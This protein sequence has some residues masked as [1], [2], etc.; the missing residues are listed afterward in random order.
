MAPIPFEPSELSE[1]RIARYVTGACSDAEAAETRAW[2]AADP[3]RAAHAAALAR[4]WAAARDVP[5][6]HDAAAAWRAV[7][8]RIERL[9]GAAAPGPPT[10]AAVPA[11][12][13]RGVAGPPRAAGRR[14]LARRVASGLAAAGALAAGGMMLWRSA[15]ARDAEPR[16]AADRGREFTTRRGQ[17]AKIVLLD[18]TRVDL[19]AASR[20][21]MRAF[22]AG[23]REVELDGEAVFD[24]VHDPARPFLVRARNAVTEDLG[25]RFGV[26]AYADEAHV[27]VVVASGEV[28]LRPA[29][30]PAGT[31]ALLGAGDAARLDA[32][33]RSQVESGV[34]LDDALGWVRG[35]LV[36]ARTP[37]GEAVPD[38]E[39][40]YDVRI[41]LA[42]PAL[43]TRRVTATFETES[44]GAAMG[45]LALLVGAR[46]ELR[47]REVVFSP[48]THP[49]AATDAR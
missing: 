23:S 29:G 8:E 18:G 27:R 20:L 34:S 1:R 13:P 14:R 19:A 30:A 28:A 4:V 48:L 33:G 3:A 25:T 35:R 49:P 41:R 21:R 16:V 17:R 36:L 43:A 10:L 22:G 24:V 46:A 37:L 38:L 42:D 44:A 26:R 7:W 11:A 15:P 45:A 5:P 32:A 31:G 47:G 2:I 9:D 6:R 40:W 12:R 39:R